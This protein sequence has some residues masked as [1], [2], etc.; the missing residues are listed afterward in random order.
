MMQTRLHINIAATRAAG[1]DL[2]ITWRD[3]G[4]PL[5]RRLADEAHHKV[6]IGCCSLRH[7]LC[8]ASCHNSLDFK[9]SFIKH[10]TSHTREAVIV[11][12]T[13]SQSSH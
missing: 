8:V 11:Q 12:D 3:L 7:L 13:L 1:L 6:L 2:C 5:G 10:L 9:T 4:G